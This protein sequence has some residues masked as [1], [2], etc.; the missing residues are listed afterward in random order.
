MRHTPIVSFSSMKPPEAIIHNSPPMTHGVLI[1]DR[2]TPQESV[3]ILTYKISYPLK[4]SPDLTFLCVSSSVTLKT[5]LNHFSEKFKTLICQVIAVLYNIF[6]MPLEIK[7]YI[8][9]LKYEVI[10]TTR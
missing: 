8:C 3:T 9:D 2:N 5:V 6:Y 10:L 4:H 7:I 1:L